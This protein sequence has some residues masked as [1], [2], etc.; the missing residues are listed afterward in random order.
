[1]DVQSI[2]LSP[3]TGCCQAVGDALLEA[4]ANGEQALSITTKVL[5]AFLP[6]S[7]SI[8]VASNELMNEGVRNTQPGL[9]RETFGSS[10]IIFNDK[11]GIGSAFREHGDVLLCASR[12]HF[13]A[14][15]IESFRGCHP[16]RRY[17]LVHFPEHGSPISNLLACTT[18]HF[19]TLFKKVTESQNAYKEFF[20]KGSLATLRVVVSRKD[21]GN[22]I[23]RILT[24][25]ALSLIEMS[26]KAREKVVGMEESKIEPMN[27]QESTAASPKEK[28]IEE[29]DEESSSESGQE[30]IFLEDKIKD[31]TVSISVETERVMSVS[32][33]EGAAWLRDGHPELFK[34]AE[35]TWEEKLPSSPMARVFA[36]EIVHCTADQ[37]ESN[38]ERLKLLVSSLSLAESATERSYEIIPYISMLTASEVNYFMTQGTPETKTLLS[39]L[40]FVAGIVS[41]QIKYELEKQGHSITKTTNYVNLG[42]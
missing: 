7:P 31:D 11:A 3:L 37:L 21:V 4:A 10:D 15:A 25:R 26:K 17:S 24:T 6:N 8:T 5:Q 32:Y 20:D 2:A 40:A 27:I 23:T 34:Q 36:E 13:T 1:V 28:V 12:K 39:M 22:V 18:E 33:Q 9:L 30:V 41:S 38:A 16:G 19:D 29:K 14:M 42:E 35:K